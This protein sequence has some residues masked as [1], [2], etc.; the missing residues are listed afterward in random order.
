MKDITNKLEAILLIAA[1]PLGV[2]R[3]MSAVK[4]DKSTVNNGLFKLQKFYA[5]G[6]RGMRLIKSGNNWQLVT[7]P[8]YGQLVGMFI[9][10]EVSGELTRPSLEALTIISYRGPI[11]KAE[12]EQIRGVNC[13]LIIRNLLIR[14]FIEEVPSKNN[15]TPVFQVT[16]DFLKYLG[17]NRVSEL[18][19]YDK[20]NKHVALEKFLQQSNVQNLQ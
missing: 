5:D 3:L 10:E 6:K 8:E 4:A 11:S 15:L 17:V 18:P 2:K 12:L 7:A 14:G 13:S 16:V 9:K 20:L 1:R 19:D